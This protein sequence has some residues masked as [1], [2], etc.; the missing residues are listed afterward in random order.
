MA[1]KVICYDKRTMNDTVFPGPFMSFQSTP[2][3]RLDDLQHLE[4]VGAEILHFSR[5]FHV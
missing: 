2:C 1:V 5:L 3:N 4:G